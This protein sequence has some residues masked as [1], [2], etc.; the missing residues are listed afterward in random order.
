ML[1]FSTILNLQDTVTPDDFI[2][3][4]GIMDVVYKKAGSWHII[5]YKT[6]ADP[7]DLDEK[8][9]AQMTA[10]KAAFR[11]KTGEEADAWV[12]HINIE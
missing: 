11:E 9:R 12:Y 3:W 1:L 5:D 7:D 6:N 10:Y 2:R 8:Y 4:H